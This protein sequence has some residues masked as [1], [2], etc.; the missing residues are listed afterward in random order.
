MPTGII[1]FYIHT[2]SQTYTHTHTHLYTFTL[3][4]LPVT[5]PCSRL[6]NE[7][8]ETD[9][10]AAEKRGIGSLWEKG[11]G[12]TGGVGWGIEQTSNYREAEEEER[13]N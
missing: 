11:K 13:R 9:K 6:N 7:L 8:C 10:V 5:H 2:H 3:L 12:G 1:R 4:L